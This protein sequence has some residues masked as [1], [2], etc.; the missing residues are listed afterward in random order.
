MG[1]G[2]GIAIKNIISLKSPI[3]TLKILSNPTFYTRRNFQILPPPFQSPM[4]LLSSLILCI[5]LVLY[6]IFYCC[7]LQSL[8]IQFMIYSLLYDTSKSIREFS[9]FKYVKKNNWSPRLL[10]SNRVQSKTSVRF[11]IFACYKA[12]LI[13]NGNFQKSLTWC[14]VY[15]TFLNVFSFY[16]PPSVSILFIRHLH[17]RKYDSHSS[18]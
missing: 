8:F 1:G 17:I 7:F 18:F 9:S 2:G 3:S 13:F 4:L 16:S 5:P 10:E 11:Y 15:Q 12:L 6:Y 14:N